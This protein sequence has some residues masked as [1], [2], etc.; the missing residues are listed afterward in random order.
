MAWKRW[1]ALLRG[2]RVSWCC[3]QVGRPEELAEPAPAP[4]PGL[5]EGWEGRLH[6]FLLVWPFCRASLQPAAALAPAALS[7]SP[8][9]PGP[10][11]LV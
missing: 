5:G 9:S 2:L 1:R 8:A 4:L 11:L 3:L 6:H 10:L 7:L